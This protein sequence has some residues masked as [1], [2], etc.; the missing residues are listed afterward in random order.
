V[1]LITLLFLLLLLLSSLLIVEA[2]INRDRELRVHEEIGIM[3]GEDGV[4]ISS[5]REVGEE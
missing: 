3:R 2:V 4:K 1:L 5:A